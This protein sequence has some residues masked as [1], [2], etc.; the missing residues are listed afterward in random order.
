M[1]KSWEV[2]SSEIVYQKKWLQ[3]KEER[4]KLPDGRVLDPYIIINVPSFC[5]VFIVTEQDEIVLVKQ[6]RHA[7]GIISLE[8]PGGMI[9]NGEDPLTAIIREMREE[10][11]YTSADVS[12]LYTIHPNPPLEN[13]KAWFYL[14]KNAKQTQSISLD[15][16]EDIELVLIPKKDFIQKLL[17]HEFTHGAQ[18]GAMYA[19][20]IQLG[21][22]VAQ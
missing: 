3:V 14:A 15:A 18:T 2:L 20:A 21:W 19:A 12:L 8:L 13:N 17:N 16:F 1:V 22:L 9:D 11:G 7:A 6:Y 10:T 4:C 5:N